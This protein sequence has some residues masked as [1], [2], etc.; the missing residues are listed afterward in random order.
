MKSLF[1]VA[2][3][4][5]GLLYFVSAKTARHVVLQN[6]IIDTLNTP[7]SSRLLTDTTNVEY[8]WLVHVSPS[9]TQNDK[10]ALN[11]YIKPYSLGMYLPHNTYLLVSPASAA[12][13]LLDKE[14]VLWIGE[15]E[16]SQKIAPKIEEHLD[17]SSLTVVL[18]PSS[19]R[20][21]DNAKDLAFKWVT[22]YY[23]QTQKEVKIIGVRKDRLIAEVGSSALLQAA[24][25]FAEQPETHWVEPFVT[26]KF[27]NKYA[28][29]VILANN[30]RTSTFIDFAHEELNGSS[31]VIAI[32][33]TGLNFQSCY[34]V[35]GSIPGQ[36]VNETERKVIRYF[37]SGSG[38][39]VDY[40]GHG[41]FIAGIVAGASVNTDSSVEWNGLAPGAKISFFDIDKNGTGY[42]DTSDFKYTVFLTAFLDLAGVF[43]SSFGSP[44]SWYSSHAADVD[45]VVFGFEDV[46]F[47]TAVG[48]DQMTDLAMSKNALVVGASQSYTDTLPVELV[49]NAALAGTQM[50]ATFSA[51]GPTP[52]GRIKP[53]VV[54]PGQ[55]ITSA[56]TGACGTETREGTSYAAAVGGAAAAIVRDFFTKNYFTIGGQPFY[57]ISQSAALIKAV[58]INSAQ[59]LKAGDA[60]G[61]GEFIA[62]E[63]FWPSGYQGFGRIQLDRALGLEAVSDFNLNIFDDRDLTSLVTGQ[64]VRYC[65]RV[66]PDARYVKLT[67]VWSDPPASPLSGVALVNDL[68]AVIYD[69]SG[70]EW[71]SQTS[72]NWDRLNNV[73]QIYLENPQPGM[74]AYSIYGY[75]VSNNE[76]QKWA[77]AISGDAVFTVGCTQGFDSASAPICPNGCSDRGNC[78]WDGDNNRAYCSCEAGFAGVDCSVSRC[79]NNCGGNGVCDHI[80]AVCRCNLDFDPLTGCTSKVQVNETQ[81]PPPEVIVES[82]ESNIGYFIGVGIGGLVVGGIIFGLIGFFCAIKYIERKRDQLMQG[83]EAEMN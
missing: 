80:A 47:V 10:V 31:Q 77:L 13:K 23:I 8:Q 44:T 64:T 61:K 27:Q 38:D 9:I 2:V 70:H 74:Y 21:L 30:D 46:L 32:A 18:S 34:F 1:T 53:D 67:L 43:V 55:R 72:E 29:E 41:T 81:A 65:M 82:A 83:Q 22:D 50:L 24:E 63:N 58:L 60:N 69:R 20:T 35:G 16:A 45:E 4:L 49:S 68:D 75:R 12:R 15:L 66:K 17:A 48:N 71:R 79:P 42:A 5:C 59:S 33:D 3:V 73:E 14:K 11:K 37:I 26:P 7:S 6:K 54:A 57:A 19:T 25:W 36:E 56:S 78:T 76:A 51:H 52:D 39:N 40:D 62:L 28:S